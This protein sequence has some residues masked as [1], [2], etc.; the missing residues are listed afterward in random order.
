MKQMLITAMAAA[1]V[2]YHQNANAQIQHEWQGI[3]SNVENLNSGSSNVTE[4][5][6]DSLW[7][8]GLL[9]YAPGVINAINKQLFFAQ[10]KL[11]GNSNIRLQY[12]GRRFNQY[13]ENDFSIS[14]A[15]VYSDKVVAGLTC[16]YNSEKF[17]NDYKTISNWLVIPQCRIIVSNKAVLFSSIKINLLNSKNRIDELQFSSKIDCSD[18]LSLFSDVCLRANYSTCYV[19]LAYQPT[20]RLGGRISFDLLNNATAGSFTIQY[21]RCA[22]L[23]GAKYNRYLGFSPFVGIITHL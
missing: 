23:S 3:L 15:R 12:Q 4:P 22:F 14:L 10:K 16:A 7:E 11:S 19:G 6:N 5:L 2:L 1:M 17:S 21:N 18:Q 13:A 9:S 8:A 20:E